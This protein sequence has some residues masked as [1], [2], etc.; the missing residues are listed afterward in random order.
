MTNLSF[1]KLTKELFPVLV[2]YVSLVDRVHGEHHPEFHEVRQIFAVIYEKTNVANTETPDLYDEF[3]QLKEVTQDY[4]I[5]EDVCE[6]YE[7]VYEMLKKLSIA[8]IK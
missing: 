6:T 8:Y 2:Q 1:K 3:T 4:A 5:P 7:T